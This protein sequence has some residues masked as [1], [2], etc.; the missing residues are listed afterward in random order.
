MGKEIMFYIKTF[1]TEYMM[2]YENCRFTK[3]LQCIRLD[4]YGSKFNKN[5]VQ[6]CICL[7]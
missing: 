2:R 1:F 4:F 3:P 7:R 5:S 6:L